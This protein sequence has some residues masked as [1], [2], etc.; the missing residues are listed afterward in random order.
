MLGQHSTA[1][2][3]KLLKSHMILRDVITVDLIENLLNLSHTKLTH[4]T[5]STGAL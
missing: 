3:I 5:G 1:D 4:L 2:C